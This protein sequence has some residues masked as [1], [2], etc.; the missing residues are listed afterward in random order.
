VKKV[1]HGKAVLFCIAAAVVAACGGGGGGGTLAGIDGTGSPAPAPAA[2]QSYG[3]ITAFGSVFVNGVRFDTS[4][5]QFVIDGA[6]GTQ[7]DLDVGDVVLVTGSIDSDDAAA[8]TA[9]IIVFDDAVQGPVQSIDEVS[10]TL[11]VLGQTVRITADTSFDDLFADPSI[12]G[13]AVGDIVEVSGLRSS[14]GS[15]DATRIEPKPAG[16]EF[17][18][19][20]VVHNLDSVAMT[21]M[22]D[23]LV[24]DYG[25]AMLNDFE[26]GAISDG[27]L[28]E[29][30]GSQLGS[31]G[32]LLAARVERKAGVVSTDAGDRVEIEG[33]VTRFAGA[34][35]FDVAGLPVTTVDATEFEG[36]SA[37][38]LGPD[39]KVEAEG[40]MDSNGVLVAS[41]IEIRHVATVRLQAMVDS[42]DATSD[43]FIA[44][45]IEIRSDALT[46]IEDKS[47]LDVERFAVSDLVAGDYVEVHGT[48]S[49]AGSDQ[50]LASR[51]E[52]DD[53]DAETELQGFVQMV[54]EPS[55]T[56]LGV[57]ISTD[58]ATEF[59][60]AQGNA[61][62]AS[63]FFN[64]LSVG[65]LV[66]A[67]GLEVADQALAA[68]QVEL[69]S[70]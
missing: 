50:I 10:G 59:R 43:T 39:V 25:T 46:R 3:T 2:T 27:D 58:G 24:V 40:T 19:T 70:E 6:S 61:I 69:E 52:R 36:G 13:I 1:K 29:V 22:I 15:I 17:E 67:N 14:D 38:D 18:T 41:K 62:N 49:S 26:S 54:S 60:D 56:I 5:T 31:G 45:G 8:G 23:S 20:G 51:I 9:S 64:A 30:K 65:S 53:P 66:E 42:V 11:V 55:F 32:E 4:T 68:R 28:V 16:L 7:S 12:A 21:F 33:L 34:T 47:D 48:E 37:T 35:D 63:Q 57:T 44:L